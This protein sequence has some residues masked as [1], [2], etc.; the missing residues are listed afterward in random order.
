MLPGTDKAK[1]K[2]SLVSTQGR[3]MLICGTASID[4]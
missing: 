2:R 4:R 3:S 1:E